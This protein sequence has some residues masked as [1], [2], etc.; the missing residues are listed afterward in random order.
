[1]KFSTNIAYE[2]RHRQ[3]PSQ[4][5]GQGWMDQWFWPIYNENGDPY[6]TFSGSRN[7]VGGLLNGGT[8]H[9]YL[10]TLRGNVQGTY[11]FHK[12]LKGLTLTGN[13]A[14][15]MVE[16]NSQHT[17]YKVQYYD[18]VGTPTGNK[19]SPGSMDQVNKRWENMNLSAMLNY[20]N[21]FANVHNV[22]AMLGMTA[23][24]ET[25]KGLSASRNKGPLFEGS[26]LEDLNMFQG[27]D[28]NG[29]GGGKNSW[30]LVS[31]I[32]R[33]NYDYDNRYAVEFLGRRDGSSKLATNQRWKNFYS[34]SGYWRISGEKW[35]KSL[36]W[37]NDL[38]LRYNYGKTGSVEG[39]GNYERY[40]TLS[41][42]STIL[43]INPS[44]HTTM[45]LGGMTSDQRSWETIESHNFGLDFTLLNNRL[46]GSF[47]YFIKNNTG[48]FISVEYPQVLGASAPKVNDG[49]FGAR[50]W[51]FALNWRDKIGEVKYNV[52]FNLADARSEVKK[53]TNN[54]NVPNA[55]LNS[56]RLIGKPRN[57]IYVYKTDGLFQNQ[58]EVD[59]Y[60][61][62]YY[63]NAD[64]T[65]PKEGN[66]LPAPG[67]QKTN[68]LRPGARKVVDLDG[69]GVITR[70]DIYYAGDAAPRLSFG[71]KGGL[72]WKGIDF[73]M[74]FQG[75][76][77]QKILRTGNMYAPWV[78]NYTRQNVSFMGKMWSEENPNAE[79]AIAS[80]DAAFNRWN[81]QNK[82]VSVQN[83]KYI[84]LKSLVVGYTLP[85]AWT[86]KAGINKLRVY[87]SGDDL[88]EWTKVK[89]GYDPEYGEAS[90]NTFPF[91]RQITFGVDLTF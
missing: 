38:K 15:K 34:V 12:L 50:G 48:M 35:M 87:F 78:V 6:D 46:S 43:G 56:N 9:Y 49:K 71:I 83:N 67:K 64:H 33:L 58:A 69:D 68:T 77:K 47:D 57:S 25:Y 8:Y 61:D 80:R 21:T 3:T 63:W 2:K 18:W 75:I 11:D 1:M 59:A 60:Y 31:Y 91:S 85:K 7:P 27:G 72:E 53:L 66:I 37:L 65:G 4:D 14:Y 82:D 73:N 20:K 16:E 13:A 10:T 89:D 45:W 90:N 55:G 42:G 81:Y 84:R 88:W 51:E 29:A 30:G 52:G 23:E 39:I 5:L 41:T 70:D 62:K 22:A 44:A 19:K 26:G 24:Q 74:F 32:T 86:S 40:A 76:G 17:Y 79:Y 54:E 36:T 28:N